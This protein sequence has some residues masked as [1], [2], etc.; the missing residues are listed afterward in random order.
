MKRVTV[1]IVCLLV[2]FIAAESSA[3]IYQGILPLSKLGDVKE[4]FPGATFKKLFP[5]WAKEDDV[6][7]SV[8]GRGI[9][10]EIIIKFK[11]TRVAFK[12][13]MRNATDNTDKEFFRSMAERTED[14]SLY[15]SWVRWIPSVPFPLERMIKK[16]GKP[17]KSDFYSDTFQP[18]REW[19]LKGI[20]AHLTDDEKKVQMID[21]FFTT[22]DFE[23]KAEKQVEDLRRK[24]IPPKGWY[25]GTPIDIDKS[26]SDMGEPEN[27]KAK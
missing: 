6:M 23:K 11:D 7:Y 5:A 19:T 26:K 10:G 9:T 8:T 12:E 24:S 14:S 13:I 15:V 21:F 27:K 4:M 3:E 22:A 16:Y 20:Q 17:N 1:F 2:C 25:E 18:Y